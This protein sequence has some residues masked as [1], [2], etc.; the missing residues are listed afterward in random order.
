MS[1]K[2]PHETGCLVC[3]AA[4]VYGRGLCQPDY[5][6]FMKRLKAI[7]SAQGEN[8]AEKFEQDCLDAGWIRPK[9]KGGRQREEN[10][11]DLIADR[12]VA[13]CKGLY[14]ATE[15]DATVA[16]GDAVIKKAVPTRRKNGGA[17]ANGKKGVQ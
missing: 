2:K 1:T 10:P 14:T 13:D 9:S 8:A 12:V 17:K 6:H 15:A 5:R 16:D 3:G 4:D 7:E 11:L